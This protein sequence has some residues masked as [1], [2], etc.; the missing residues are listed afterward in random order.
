MVTVPLGLIGVFIIF[1]ITHTN[2]DSSAYIGVILLCG[3][4]VNNGIILI[5]HINN[6]RRNGMEL[7]S[8]LVQACQD[9]IRPILMTTATTIFGL[10]P[11][12]LLDP[13]KGEGHA[14]IWYTLSL[15]TIG[16]LITSTIF[17][18]TVI[19]VFYLLFERLNIILKSE[20]NELVESSTSNQQF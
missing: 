1:L 13:G 8:A 12:V 11:F 6:L 20:I 4:V 15:S 19:P 5:D 18:L 16:G 9:R 2:F 17:T 3:I 14:R 10:L 7:H